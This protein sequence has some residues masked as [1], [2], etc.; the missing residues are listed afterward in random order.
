MQIRRMDASF[1]KLNNASL[2]LQPGLNLIY[3]PNESG[4]STWCHFIRTMLYGLPKRER[5]ALAEKNRFSPW[6]G[7][8]MSGV[9]EIEAEGK[10]YTVSRRTSSPTSP[11]GEFS[12][13]YTGTSTPIPGITG[14]DLGEILLG[15]GREVFTRSAFIGQGGMS[16]DSDAELERRISALVTSGE[17]DISYSES[18]ERLKKQLNRRRHNKTGLLPSLEQEIRE[19]HTTLE[20]M[21]DLLEQ[22]TA[23]REQLQQYTRQ[24]NDLQTRLQQWDALEKQEALQRYRQA[25]RDALAAQQYADTLAAAAPFLPEEAELARLMGMADTLDQTLSATEAAGEL[26]LQQ[27]K[28]AASA[29]SAWQAH[30]LHPADEGCLSSQ[31]AILTAAIKPFSLVSLLLSLLAGTAAGAGLWFWLQQPLP[32]A[33]A[34][35]SVFLLLLLLLNGLRR[36]NNCRAEERAAQ[37]EADCCAYLHL[38]QEAEVQKA[39][40]ERSTAAARSLHQSCRQGLAELLQRTRPFAP[41]VSNLTNVSQA[42]REALSRRRALDQAQD[43]ARQARL[44]CRLLHEHLPQGPLP[45]P[46]KILPRPTTS[47]EQIRD[48]LPRAMAGAQAAQSQLDKLHGQL[49]AMGER[50]VW[51]SRLAQKEQTRQRLQAEY[52]AIALA[53]D[54]LQEADAALHSRFSPLLS[55]RAAKIFSAL[56]RGIYDKVLFHRDFSLSAQAIAEITP[57][58]AALLSHGAADQLYLA[59]RLAICQM[60]LPEDKPA[61]LI[62]DDALANFDDD[63]MAAALDWLVEESQHRQI[64]LFTCQRREGKYLCDRSGVNHLHL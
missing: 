64:L 63:R 37:F 56:T 6:N 26:A 48:S 60:V 25:E 61:P 44:H 29:Q 58:S 53:M 35:G 9:M 43:D 55:Q 4:K 24:T 51:E 45:E 50:D 20:T 2:R 30:P 34:A 14:Q 22:M 59:V 36:R 11:M 27:Q 52:D 42:L 16:L 17:E 62:L 47:A 28:A 54:A 5:G 12:C 1:G 49:I 40:A 33:S 32:A 18:C 38:R 57:H 46:D 19:L 13:T 23:A 31:K 21:Q 41:D 7:S 15:I 3:A 10:L 39:E 8:P